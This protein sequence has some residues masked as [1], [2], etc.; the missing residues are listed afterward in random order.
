MARRTCP[1]TGGEMCQRPGKW[2]VAPRFILRDLVGAGREGNQHAGRDA[3]VAREPGAG[4]Q[5]AHA[6]ALGRDPRGRQ[7]VGDVGLVVNDEYAGALTDLLSRS[8]HN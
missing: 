5:G 4:V 8:G 3:G 2:A 7:Q 6:P 1:Q